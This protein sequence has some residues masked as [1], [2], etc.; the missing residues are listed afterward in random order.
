IA[1]LVVAHPDADCIPVMSVV[2]LGYELSDNRQFGP[3]WREVR[4]EQ[5]SDGLC[6]VRL[7]GNLSGWPSTL[8]PQ[9]K[10]D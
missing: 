5:V 10:G 6:V 4:A 9:V 1:N 7:A 2:R 3:G 8:T